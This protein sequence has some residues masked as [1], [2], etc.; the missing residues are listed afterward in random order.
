MTLNVDQGR[1]RWHNSISRVSL[2][3][4]GP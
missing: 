2:C 1:W 3:F 4:T